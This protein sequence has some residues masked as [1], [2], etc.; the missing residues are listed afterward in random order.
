MDYLAEEQTVSPGVFVETVDNVLPHPRSSE[1]R[2]QSQEVLG[3]PQPP[4]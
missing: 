1:G 2:L 4:Y 3:S